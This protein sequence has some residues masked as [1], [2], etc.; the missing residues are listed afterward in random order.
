M[1]AD[2][3][4]ATPGTAF[5]EGLRL[6]IEEAWQLQAA[7]TALREARGERV[8]GYKIGCVFKG[9]QKMMGLSHPAYGRLWSD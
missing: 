4:N 6:E 3:D 5:G 1:L 8:V 2:Y 9:N 7:V